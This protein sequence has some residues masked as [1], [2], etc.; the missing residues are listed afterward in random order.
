[1]IS[2]PAVGNKGDGSR[3]L[4][5]LLIAVVAVVA[6]ISKCSSSPDAVG[7]LSGN[8]MDANISAGVAAQQ[9]PPVEPLDKASVTRGISHFRL[10]YDAEAFPGA[11]I[12]S[13]NCYDALTHKFTWTKLDACGG[14]DMFAVRAMEDSHARSIESEAAY[15]DSEA[16]AGR[17]LAAATGGGE[18]AAEADNRLSDLQAR[19]AGAALPRSV[20]KV[21]PPSEGDDAIMNSQ[22]SSGS[23]NGETA[24]EDSDE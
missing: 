10:A 19:T 2:A 14:F 13:Q 23:E 11:M 5:V 22:E 7:T 15:F 24:T 12:Y 16:A 20:R 4:V 17:Y 8:L 1:L 3:G 9:P 21:V 6:M 18:A